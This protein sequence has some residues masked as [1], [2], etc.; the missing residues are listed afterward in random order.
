MSI[1]NKIID[2]VTSKLNSSQVKA[3]EKANFEIRENEQKDIY[4][5]ITNPNHFATEK[6]GY[7]RVAILPNEENELEE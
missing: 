7:E 4:L 2:L 6:C 3:K 1:S 5:E